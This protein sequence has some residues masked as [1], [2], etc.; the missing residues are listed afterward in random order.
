MTTT[1]IDRLNPHGWQPNE[2]SIFRF[3][4]QYLDGT[5]TRDLLTSIVD[6]DILFLDDPRD[7]GTMVGFVLRGC[8]ETLLANLNF[9]IDEDAADPGVWMAHDHVDWFRGA[10][11]R[12]AGNLITLLDA[13]ARDR[14]VGLVDEGEG[15][16]VAY[17]FVEREAEVKRVLNRTNDRDGVFGQLSQQGDIYPI[18]EW[19]YDTPKPPA[20]YWYWQ[21]GNRWIAVLE[22]AEQDEHGRTTWFGLGVD[23][24]PADTPEQWAR[25][26]WS[27]P[28]DGTLIYNLPDG[29]TAE[30][31][32]DQV[33]SRVN[34]P[35]EFIA[36]YKG[37][38]ITEWVVLPL[39][40]HA[41]Y[42]GSA[43]VLLDGDADLN[44][45]S[46]DGPFWRAVQA[47]VGAPISVRWEE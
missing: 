9:G 2:D 19:G 47:E 39:A 15:G 31:S 24:R 8:E 5:N 22:A 11:E 16:I 46:T 28:P 42:F 37:G 27:L 12:P 6:G 17:L 4:T 43:A 33:E 38:K 10:N 40:S 1:T 3:H 29:S 41:G 21:S 30:R 26:I 7:G 34:I 44:V 18:C 20:D 32:I 14:L 36:H 25:P 35:C 23:E 45:E 13:I